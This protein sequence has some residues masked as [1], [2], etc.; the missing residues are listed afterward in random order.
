MLQTGRLRDYATGMLV[1]ASA[2]VVVLAV[3][4]R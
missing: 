2:F 1:A 3:I 4:V